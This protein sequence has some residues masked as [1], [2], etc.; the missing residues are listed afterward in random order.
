MKGSGFIE[1]IKKR[2]DVR[3]GELVESNRETLVEEILG[4]IKSLYAREKV[5]VVAY[6]DYHG[7]ETPRILNWRGTKFG[8]T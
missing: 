7:E 1:R 4:E 2:E 6:S 5:E 8:A 3:L